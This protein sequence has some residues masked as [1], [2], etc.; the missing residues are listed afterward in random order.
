MNNVVKLYTNYFDSYE[1]TYD[2]GDLNEKEGATSNGLKLLAWV[3]MS[4]QNG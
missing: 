4:Y 2:E 3:I 1:E